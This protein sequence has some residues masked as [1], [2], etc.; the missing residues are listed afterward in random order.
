[1]SAQGLGLH[2]GRP[3]R[4]TLWPAAPGAG[5]AFACRAGGR[6]VEIPADVDHVVATRA[7]TTLGCDGARVATVEHLLAALHGLGVDDAR[8][9][10]EGGE[11]PALDGSAAGFVCLLRAAGLRAHGPPVQPL[12]L[13]E[14]V[15]VRSRVGLARAEP[16]PE[17]RIACAIAFAHPALR[18]QRVEFAALGPQRFAREL[19]PARTF[20]FLSDAAAL[21]AAG[22]ARGASP[23]NALV[24]DDCGIVAPGRL[25][26]PDEAARHKALDLLGD[27]ALLGR[28]L[29]AALHVERA[30]HALHVALVRELRAR[31]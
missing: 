16:A 1:V 22:L 5:I 27:L 4:V 20:G 18:C 11:V 15:E 3:A 24:F 14:P 6:R 26:W 19:A 17:L 9:E 28:P 7:A 8:I 13:R 25:R 29:R 21:R 23:A 30:G 10:V 12:A 2:G 31:L